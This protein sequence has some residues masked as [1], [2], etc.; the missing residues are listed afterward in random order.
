MKKLS[1]IIIV[2]VAFA[3]IIT[4][5]LAYN[6]IWGGTPEFKDFDNFSKDY[7]VMVKFATECYENST[8]KPQ[9]ITI[10]LSDDEAWK[11]KT[12]DFDVTPLVLTKEQKSALKTINKKFGTL[13]VTSD[14][15]IF[16]IDETK[17]YGLVYSENPLKTILDMR[18]DWYDGLN[19]CRINSN[20]YEIGQYAR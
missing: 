14:S 10:S 3:T 11:H 6:F 16:W 17:T 2:V 4:G 1:K 13:W 12:K 7:E 18:N 15:V 19:Y 20:W 9:H 5:C 8:E